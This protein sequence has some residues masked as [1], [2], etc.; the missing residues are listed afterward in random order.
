M[1][2][3][4]QIGTATVTVAFEGGRS[5]QSA[6]VDV[7][8]TAVPGATT[9]PA[10]RKNFSPDSITAGGLNTLIF[11]IDNTANAASTTALAFTDNLPAGVFV[12]PMPNATTSCDGGTVTAVA[13]GA[14]V[15]YTG[16][17]VVAI[18]AP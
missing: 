10:F 16:G 5:P 18:C 14:A 1:T 11:T 13:G 17:A 8:I 3:E 9:A 6:S 7:E 4:G 15:S 12:A 2:A